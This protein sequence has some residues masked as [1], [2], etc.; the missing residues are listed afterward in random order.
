MTQ[1]NLEGDDRQIIPSLV[2]RMRADWNSRAIED[3][4]FFIAFG[5][6]N[7][8]DEGFNATAAEVVARIRRD[9]HWLGPDI[10]VRS[11]RFLEIG[12]GVGRLVRNLANDCGEIHGVDIS[13]EMIRLGQEWLA[14]VPHAHLH[15][16]TDSDLRTFSNDYFDVVYSYAVMQHLPDRILFWR[17]LRDAFRVL[18]VGGIL[19]AQFNGMQIEHSSPDTW[20]GIT[21]SAKEVTAAC[22]AAGALV[23]SLEGESTQYVWITAQKAD[24]RPNPKPMQRLLDIDGVIGA[25]N[26]QGTIVAGGPD[27]FLSLFVRQLPD[28][29]CDV[30]ELTVQIGSSITSIF[31]VGCIDR[32]GQRQI[33]AWVP[34]DTPIG[35]MPVRLLWRNL[36]V[37]SARSVR[38]SRPS[39]AS[40]RILM[41][42]DGQE[43]GRH[44]VVFCGWAKIWITDLLKADLFRATVGGI[45]VSEMDFLSE[46]ARAR[47][48]QINIRIPEGVAAGATDLVVY[49]GGTA[50]SAVSLTIFRD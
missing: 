37:S 29:F 22:S 17:Y 6:R 44:N 8:Q 33:S 31:Y 19:V 21:V 41:V 15:V 49:V 39:P 1:S 4:R 45:S 25:E 18:K 40:P 9:L 38:V 16:T 24:N 11:R 30:T 28:E 2:Q 3:A 34:D 26:M 48:Y 12:C 5:E 43:V 13:D 32:N 20:S 35:T 47:R 42:T 46:D 23:R 36:V 14:E 27:G 7:Q 10:S 50:L